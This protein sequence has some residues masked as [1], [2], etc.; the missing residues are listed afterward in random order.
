MQAFVARQTKPVIANVAVA[1]EWAGWC[2][3]LAVLDD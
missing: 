1:R 2:R 3:S